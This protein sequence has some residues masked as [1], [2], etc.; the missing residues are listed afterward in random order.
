M[1]KIKKFYSGKIKNVLV[2]GGAGFIGSHLCDSLIKE[3][4]VICL[5]NFVGGGNVNNIKHLLQKPNFRFIKHDIN[6]QVDFEKFPELKDFKIK[7]HSLQ[8]IYHLACPTSAK[9][10]DK[11]RIQT[12]QANSV[13]ILN[14]LEM[15]RFYKA[16]MLFTSSSVVYGSRSKEKQVF[17][18]NDFGSVNFTGPRSCYDEGKRF[19][20]TAI[21]TYRDVYGIDAK[22]ARVF[23]T[24]GPREALFDGQMIPDFVL[25]AIN[26]KPLIIY[27]NE[28]F[29]TSLCEV[30]DMVSGL[31]ALMNSKELGPI[32]LGHP[33]KYKLVDLAQRI[34]QLTNSQSKVEF[35][36]ALVFMT[37]LGLPDI[38]LAREKL[39]W[40]PIIQIDDGLRK[41][42]DYVNANRVLL[43]PLVDKNDQKS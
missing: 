40:F 37:A 32:N 12:L 30:N 9:N 39:E 13:G 38:S 25:Q 11:L 6:Q 18:E 22:I 33:Q 3:N 15:A 1:F 2:T 7:I 17:K 21:I 29:A 5:D 4:N 14:V 42:I 41:L 8:E 19:A 36:T 31:I 20:E 16:K 35:R 34:I 43:Q 23:R 27:G 28:V 26:N 24:Y 10:F